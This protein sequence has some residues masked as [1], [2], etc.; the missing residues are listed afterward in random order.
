VIHVHKLNGEEFA[1]NAELIETIE[2]TPDTIVT[3]V[4]RRRFT[5]T[6]S[7]DQVIEA[8]VAYRR[9]V[10]AAPLPLPLIESG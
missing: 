8:V 10:A 2:A 3:L 9:G 7:V 1:L 5:V 6:E 4:G